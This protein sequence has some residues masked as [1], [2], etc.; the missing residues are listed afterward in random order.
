MKL[1]AT[2]YAL[3]EAMSRPTKIAPEIEPGTLNSTYDANTVNAVP[4]NKKRKI[5]R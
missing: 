2:K 5:F 1:A 3:I 4:I